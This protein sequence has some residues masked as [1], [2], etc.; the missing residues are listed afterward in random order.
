[1]QFINRIS[2]SVDP[3]LSDNINMFIDKNDNK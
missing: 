1:V 2:S 3:N